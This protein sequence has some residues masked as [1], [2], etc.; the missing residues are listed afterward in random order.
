MKNISG[1]YRIEINGKSYIGS[2]VC[3]N[4]RWKQHK[5]DLKCGRHDNIYLQRAYDKYGNA[6]FELLE[7]MPGASDKDLREK[8]DYYMNLYHAEYNIQNPTTNFLVKPVFQ[9]NLEGKFIK[10]YS[11]VYTAAEELGISSSN[12]MH[13]AQENEKLTRTAGGYFWR[14]TQ[15]IEFEKDKRW[16]EIH[17]YSIEGD[18][19]WTFKSS[20]ECVRQMNL[21]K[22]KDA[23]SRINR[24][25][26]GLAASY[27]GYR[28]SYEKV[29]KLDNSKLLS[30]K[31]YYP[32][33]QIAADKKTKIRVFE[34]A[35]IAAKVLH[36]NGNSI[37]TAA[38]KGTKCGGFYWARLGT[39]WSEM[40]ESPEDTKATK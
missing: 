36:L 35:S 30:I 24:V 3:I 6:K 34:K 37:T 7:E 40:L 20:K 25:C 26:R 10:M 8:E 13:A 4:Q 17:V 29:D 22:P 1:V 23:P 32:I 38:T 33:V 28:Y 39:K 9:F 21:P 11:D 27:G 18:Y 31:C 15:E 14:Y 19:I 2:S 12:I 5:S 16:H